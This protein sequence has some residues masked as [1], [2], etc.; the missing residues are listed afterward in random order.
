MPDGNVELIRR[1][2]GRSIW[3]R[4][5]PALFAA[6][7]C[8]APVR[9]RFGAGARF[10]GVKLWPWAWQ[11]LGGP[12]A[13]GF[14]DEWIAVPEDS[15]LARLI[16]QDDGAV[17]EALVH[18]FAGARVPALGAALLGGAGVGE[19]ARHAGMSPRGLQRHFACHYGIPPRAYL[20][21]LRL[22]EALI[23]MQASAAPLADTAAAQ[24]YADQAH[25]ARDFRRIAGV[26][27]RE[28]RARAR[29]PFL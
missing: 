20:R 12:A 28:A 27:P 24:G 11:A 4:E 18:A 8:T 23:G 26:P 6:G 13:G 5:Q 19:A 16:P 17:V 21:L 15:P 2:A 29:G 1:H 3:R 7:L 9:L 25:M 10:T 14:V 22:R